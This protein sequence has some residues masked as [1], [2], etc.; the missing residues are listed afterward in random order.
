VAGG[1]VGAYLGM[2]ASSNGQHS[3]NKADWDWFEYSD[4]AQAQV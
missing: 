2:Y 4:A 1:F 3:E